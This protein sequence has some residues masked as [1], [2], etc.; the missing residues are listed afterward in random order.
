MSLFAYITFK[1]NR[2]LITNFYT[3]DE[4]FNVC[5]S[6]EYC[7]RDELGSRLVGDAV[8]GVV[9]CGEGAMNVVKVEWCNN[10]VLLSYCGWYY[11][12]E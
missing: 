1:F 11:V 9:W 12:V 10:L 6:W 7:G 2:R 4:A 5:L 8:G 3:K